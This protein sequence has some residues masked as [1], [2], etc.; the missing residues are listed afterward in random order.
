MRVHAAL[1]PALELHP[2]SDVL[3]NPCSK[4]LPCSAQLSPAP[5]HFYF[6]FGS[7]RYCPRLGVTPP[8]RPR[9]QNQPIHRFCGRRI[10]TLR[11]ENHWLFA[12]RSSYP[13]PF[14]SLWI[15]Q[16]CPRTKNIPECNHS[17]L[18][19]KG[20]AKPREKEG[21]R[22]KICPKQPSSTLTANFDEP[23]EKEKKLNQPK[24]LS[25][26]SM[27]L[28]NAYELCE[29]VGHRP[30]NPPADRYQRMQKAIEQR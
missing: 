19:I 17:A 6:L 24:T 12:Q 25:Q 5:P 22:R 8:T 27:V 4:C 2:A 16:A 23:R 14:P 18:A 1:S 10:I 26:E 11:K 9:V 30:T 3:V 20:T 21:V 28:W 29:L 15:S 7:R 13:R